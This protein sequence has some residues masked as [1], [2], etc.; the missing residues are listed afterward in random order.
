[1]KESSENPEN[2][3]QPEPQEK[4]HI[5]GHPPLELERKGEE[6]W[7]TDGRKL[8][9][10]FEI[11][12]EHHHIDLFVEYERTF[13]RGKA[14]DITHVDNRNVHPRLL[15]ARIHYHQLAYAAP[16]VIKGGT[17]AEC[18]NLI[19][20]IREYRDKYPDLFDDIDANNPRPK[21]IIWK[22]IK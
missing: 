2:G 12:P 7:T 17:K 4:K 15:V 5:E 14:Y 22:D 11:G 21:N 13:G 10:D 20:R 1:M 18:E 16:T 19:A 9:P 3:K 6:I 8:I